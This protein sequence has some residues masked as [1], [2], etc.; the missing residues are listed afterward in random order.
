[1]VK[2]FTGPKSSPILNDKAFQNRSSHRFWTTRH[3]R[4]KSSP[5]YMHMQWTP[6]AYIY[7]RLNN[8][9]MYIWLT[10]P[11]FKQHVWFNYV[12]YITVNN[13]SSYNNPIISEKYTINHNYAQSSSPSNIIQLH[14][15]Q[16]PNNN[17]NNNSTVHK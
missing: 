14:N 12:A 9:Y 7:I 6:L 16:L 2:A 8:A 4:T 15:K 11:H 1:M 10:T 3:P 5:L 17:N 13:R